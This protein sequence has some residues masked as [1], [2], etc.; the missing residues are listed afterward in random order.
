MWK[1]WRRSYVKQGYT[2]IKY[3]REDVKNVETFKMVIAILDNHW[4][5]GFIMQQ[6]IT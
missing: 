5:I 2:S 1:Y 3:V 6:T 4:T